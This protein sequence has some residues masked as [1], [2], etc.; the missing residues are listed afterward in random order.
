MR[1]RE[2]DQRRGRMHGEPLDNSSADDNLDAAREV[3]D[4]VLSSAEAAIE[5]ALSGDSLQYNRESQ[6][7][8]GE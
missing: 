3:G 2:H 8:G 5:R 4:G 6:Q 7:A 1:F